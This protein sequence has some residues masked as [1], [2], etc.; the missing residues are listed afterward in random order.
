M[1]VSNG[2]E[3]KIY[4]SSQK[5]GFAPSKVKYPAAVVKV[6]Q[7]PFTHCSRE[8]IME[9]INFILKMIVEI[10]EQIQNVFRLLHVIS[11]YFLGLQAPPVILLFLFEML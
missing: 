7:M 4:F 8:Q 11:L 3:I 6:I 10:F 9:T 5:D 1:F 2:K